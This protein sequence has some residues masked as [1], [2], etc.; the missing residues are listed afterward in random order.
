[1]AKANSKMDSH[2]SQQSLHLHFEGDSENINSTDLNDTL[3][4][5]DYSLMDTGALATLSSSKSNR[6]DSENSDT[7]V[8][9]SKNIVRQVER[10]LLV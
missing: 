10:L 8:T 6:S 9:S 3:E 7:D 2:D 5:E 4:Y 1:M